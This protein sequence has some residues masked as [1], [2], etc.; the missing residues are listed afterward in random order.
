MNTT[1]IYVGIMII[2]FILLCAAFYYYYWIPRQLN[3]TKYKIPILQNETLFNENYVNNINI[4]TLITTRD[5]LYVPKLGYGVSFVWDMYIPSQGGS[6]KWQNDFN[7]LKPIISMGDSPVISYH[8]KKNYLSIVVKYKNN[9]FYT[10]FG[11]V[12]FDDIKLQKW[13]NYIVVIENR[14]IKLYID[15][16]LV[17]TKILPSVISIS[18]ITSEIILGEKNNNFLGKINNLS[19]YPYPLSYDDISV[20]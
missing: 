5:T 11:E 10:Q 3:T 9:P 16:V 6:D 1:L 8:P 19:L 2:I 14:N 15:R 12:R 4:A 7:H 13:S 20:V 17:S 18:D